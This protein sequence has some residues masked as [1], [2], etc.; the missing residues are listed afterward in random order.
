[1]ESEL[2]HIDL[3]E[4]A[5]TIEVP[6]SDFKLLA[7]PLIM[8]Q[9]SKT[10]DPD[11][12]DIILWIQILRG[13]SNEK[14]KPTFY[15]EDSLDMVIENYHDVMNDE[16]PKY[17][18]LILNSLMFDTAEQTTAFWH[19]VNPYEYPIYSFEIG[20]MLYGQE[21]RSKHIDNLLEMMV[22]DWSRRFGPYY[23]ELANIVDEKLN[24]AGYDYKVGKMRAIELTLLYGKE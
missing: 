13:W 20:Q 11:R 7:Y 17:S 3:K 4:R 10:N 1:M 12:N 18:E 9:F 16:P 6:E 19:F 23:R 22:Y 24:S 21:K 15:D 14:K 2:D 5:Q 8:E